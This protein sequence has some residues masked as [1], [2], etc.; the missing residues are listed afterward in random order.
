MKRKIEIVI[1]SDTHLGTFGCHA[2][3]LLSYLR[4]IEPEMLILNGD[5]III[6]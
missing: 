2:K 4:S 1:L 3:E 5:F 6:N